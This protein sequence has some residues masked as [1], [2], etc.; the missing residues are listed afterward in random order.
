[1]T[2]PARLRLFSIAGLSVNTIVGSGIFVLP[3]E[4]ARAMGASSPMAFVHAAGIISIIAIAYAVCAKR[5]TG[6]G[7]AYA[8]AREAFGPYVGYVMGFAVYAA[9]ITTW[10]TTCAAIPAQLDALIPG[11]GS[12]PR[13][14][15]TAFV[16]ALGAAN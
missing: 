12:H 2:A 11:V 7:G 8:Y 5:V 15:A 6:D 1:M 14:V 9:T 4:L 13:I 10:S 16:L 3:A